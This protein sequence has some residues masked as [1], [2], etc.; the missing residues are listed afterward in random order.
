MDEPFS[1]P[2]N[3][4]ETD[5][6]PDRSQVSAFSNDPHAEPGQVRLYSAQLLT[7]KRYIDE[8]HGMLLDTQA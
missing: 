7:L 5:S 6:N 4:C 8:M 3:G 2:N 1:N